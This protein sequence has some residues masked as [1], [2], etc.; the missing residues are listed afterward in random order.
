MPGTPRFL[1]C[2]RSS[3]APFVCDEP[4]ERIPRKGSPGYPGGRPPST[5]LSRLILAPSS[6][7]CLRG[8]HPPLDDWADDDSVITSDIEIEAIEARLRALKFRKAHQIA[9][10]CSL[11]RSEERGSARACSRGSKARPICPPASPKDS[12]SRRAGREKSRTTLNMGLLSILKKLKRDEREARILVLGLDNAGKTTILRKLSDEDI[13]QVMPTQGFNIKSLVRDGFKLN[14]WDIGGQKTIRPYWSNYFEATDGLVFVIDSADRR[15]LE[16]SG[17]ELNE[18]LQ[19]DKLGGTA[20]LVF[21]NKQDL[22]QA[23]PANEI[24]EALHLDNIRD[25]TWTIQAC[26]AKSGEGVQDGMEWLVGVRVVIISAMSQSTS[27]SPNAMPVATAAMGSGVE[28]E[29]PSKAPSYHG[30]P[31]QLISIDESGQCTADEY[32]LNILRQMEGKVVAVIGIAGLYRTGKSFLMNRLLGLQDGFEIGPSVNPCT[33]GIWMWGQPVQLGP[34][35]HAIL[36]DTEGLGSCVRTTSCDMQIFSLC[37]LLSSFFV[38]NSMGAINEESLD[39]LNLVLHLT[40]HIHVRSSSSRN[41]NPDLSKDSADL[42]AHFPPLLWVLRDF[43]LKL[44]NETGQPISP[45]EYLEHA[46]RPV[47]GRSEG[48]E[49]KNKIREC[50][51]TMFRD[52]SCSVMVRPVENE[53]DLRH[54]QKL[55]YQALRPQF[56]QQ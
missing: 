29:G 6:M 11:L 1:P 25:R 10:E 3:P 2:R 26:S 12:P 4:Q 15:R 36:I 9:V 52:R 55:P 47:A 40:K 45:K 38:Y 17:K 49:Q 37:L 35:F 53:A 39:Q 21:A 51:K 14:V 7:G 33:R 23:L 46:L 41:S 42:A 54:I 32:A 22:L 31:V 48:V 20:L 30:G 13:T 44:V 24:S 56:Q 19:E 27:S 5:D 34:N 8:H 28:E 43:N 50:I 16:E 18:L